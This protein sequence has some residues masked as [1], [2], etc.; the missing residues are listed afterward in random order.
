MRRPSPAGV[1]YLGPPRA[2]GPVLPLQVF[3]LYYDLDL[4]IMSNHPDWDMHEYARVDL[5]DGP[6][7]LAKDSRAGTLVQGIVADVDDI[8]TWLP[9]VPV[10]RRQGAVTVQDDS[11]GRKIDVQ[12]QYDNLDGQPVSVHVRGKLKDKPPGKRNGSTMGHSAQA[13]AVVLDLQRFGSARRARIEISGQKR[14]VFRLLGLV[15]MRFLLQQAQAGFAVT[16]LVQRWEDGGLRIDRPGPDPVSPASGAPRWPTSAE[17]EAWTATPLPSGRTELA[18]QGPIVRQ[19]YDF[20]DGELERARVEQLGRDQPVLELLLDPALPDLRRPFAG[21]ASSRFSVNV[22]GQLGHGSGTITARWADG[23][24]LD[25]AVTPDAPWW[26]EERPMAG[27]LTWQGDGSAAL[28]LHRI[29][30]AT[31]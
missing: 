5:P 13:A 28:E 20:R 30:A 10:P 25:L 1:A 11:D 31:D 29:P 24:R 9:E 3:G 16:N 15:P 23:D 6:L 22:N 2:E 27:S 19:V 21:T 14:G 8:G 26:L 17:D 12:L 18:H 4:V 7:W